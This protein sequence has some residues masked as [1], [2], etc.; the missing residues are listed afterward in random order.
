[1]PSPG[2]RERAARSDAPERAEPRASGLRPSGHE[3][4]DLAQQS[5]EG[6]ERQPDER[7]RILRLDRGAKSDAE[8]LALESAGA[9]ERRFALDVAL[10]GRIVERAKSNLGRVQPLP[11]LSVGMP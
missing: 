7:R 9:V 2:P 6:N 8:P 3:E 10:D 5:R 4:A 1:M 11:T